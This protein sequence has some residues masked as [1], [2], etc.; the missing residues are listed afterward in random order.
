[1]NLI[2]LPSSSLITKSAYPESNGFHRE[3]PNSGLSTDMICRGLKK[4]NLSPEYFEFSTKN[5][6]L[7][8]KIKLFKEYIYA[9]CSSGLPLILGVSIQ[10]FETSKE[11]GLHAVTILGYALNK[12]EIE[13]KSSLIS[14]KLNKIY[15]N[16]DRYGAFLRIVLKDNEFEV[17]VEQND[18]V[19]TQIDFSKEKYIPDTLIIGV[20]HKIRIPYLMIKDICLLLVDLFS[21]HL[22]DKKLNS[23]ADVIKAFEWDIHI[24]ENFVLKNDILKRRISHKEKYLTKSLPKYIWSATAIF[25]DTQIFELIFDATDIDQGTVFLEFLPKHQEYSKTIK[26]YVKDY[27]ESRFTTKDV[28]KD[29]ASL[30]WA[31]NDYFKKQETYLEN[32]ND[33]YGYL[34]IPSMIKSEEMTNDI[35][36]DHCEIRL[37]KKVDKKVFFLNKKL[38]D[39]LVYIWLIDKEGFLCIGKEKLNSRMGH[40]TLT[41]GM[42]ARIGGEMKFNP[43]N[44]TWKINPF[45]GRY[46][47]E[48]KSQEKKEYVNNAIIYKFSV[49]FPKE[50]FEN[51]KI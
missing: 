24:K 47:S 1:M 25:A 33:L 20:Y 7:E 50:K 34:K 45:S 19:T 28:K 2:N 29:S 30:L 11:K 41:N 10:D 3:F 27:F 8:N 6:S 39:N 35:I 14:H 26:K 18:E 43:S 32:L 5:I 23:V 48:Y 12:K 16:D 36:I 4:Q 37:N 31:M 21:E 9:Y 15:V 38:K 46:S 17:E 49:F 51:E 44:N 13:N 42:P 22:I 40:P